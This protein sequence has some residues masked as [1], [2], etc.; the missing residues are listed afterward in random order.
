MFNADSTKVSNISSHSSSVPEKRSDNSD[1]EMFMLDV[2]QPLFSGFNS[3]FVSS[4]IDTKANSMI[5]ESERVEKEEVEGREN[6]DSISSS[7]HSNEGVE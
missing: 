7:D 1:A 6:G 3:M 2:M 5:R 4:D